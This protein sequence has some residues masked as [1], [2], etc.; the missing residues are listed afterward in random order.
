MKVL[1]TPLPIKIFYG[2]P[3][4]SFRW[5]IFIFWVDDTGMI[6]CV[7][8]CGCATAGLLRLLGLS[9]STEWSSWFWLVMDA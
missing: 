2:T 1:E 9:L 7:C 5:F 6:D 4:L 3:E 8:W